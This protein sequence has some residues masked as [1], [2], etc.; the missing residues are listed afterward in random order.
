MARLGARELL[1]GLVNDLEGP[2]FSL[3]AELGEMRRGLEARLGRA[4]R[5][6]GSGST[7]FT[8]FDGREEAEGAAEVARGCV[9]VGT[10]VMGV[11]VCPGVG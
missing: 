2:A 11:E 10:R 3:S 1:A 7:L 5:M 6:S 4:V 9:P 8:L